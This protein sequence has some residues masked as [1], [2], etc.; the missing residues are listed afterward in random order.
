MDTTLDIFSWVAGV[1]TVSLAIGGLRMFQKRM[2][3]QRYSEQM[4]ELEFEKSL[5]LGGGL[6]ANEAQ[7]SVFLQTSSQSAE[8]EA[9]NVSG[10]H[11]NDPT[12]FLV[13]VA[14][15]HVPAD[16]A[17][18]GILQKLKLVDLMGSVEGYVELHGNPKGAAL[19]LLRNGR[20]ALLV[21]HM[22]SEAFF[23]R[24]ARRVDLFL[25]MGTDGQAV[26]ITPLE[27]FL[28]DSMPGC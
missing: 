21:P 17:A 22:E 28:A 3:S 20:R 5:Y 19:L 4:A 15:E 10:Y 25:V 24:H 16:M 11:T 2:E 27:K 12:D 1:V 18:E 6:S 7:D 8:Q 9:P 26:V 23:R 13:K 14:G